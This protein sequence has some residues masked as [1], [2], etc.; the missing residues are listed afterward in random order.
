[1]NKKPSPVPWTETIKVIAILESVY[2]AQKKGTE[3][4]VKL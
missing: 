3:V 4:K 2:A 1:M